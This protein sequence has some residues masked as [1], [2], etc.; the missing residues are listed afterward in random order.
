MDYGDPPTYEHPYNAASR[1]GPAAKRDDAWARARLVRERA[2][3][4]HPG[5]YRGKEAAACPECIAV[6]IAR[7]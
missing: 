1:F 4:F 5:P 6:R 3:C 2:T 7:V